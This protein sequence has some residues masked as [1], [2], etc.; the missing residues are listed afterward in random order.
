MT[1]LEEIKKTFELDMD[2]GGFDD[3]K[4]IIL[5]KQY[6]VLKDI[7]ETLALIYDKMNKE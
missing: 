2:L 6:K 1:R 7:S 5:Q 4:D 3:K